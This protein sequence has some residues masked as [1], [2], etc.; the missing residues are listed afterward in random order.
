MNGLPQKQRATTAA[1]PGRWA[2]TFVEVLLRMTW[3]ETKLLVREPVTLVFSFAFPVLVLVLLGGIFGGQHMDGG[4]YAG[5]KMMDWYVPSYIGLVIASIGTVSLPVHLS[6]YRERGVLRR[7][8]ASGMSEWALLGSQFL[9]GVGTCLVGA[10]AT[11]A[12]HLRLRRGRARV[13]LRRG[14]RLRG[15]RVRLLGAR[16]AHRLAR[17]HGTRR[18]G[19]RPADLVHHDVHLGH[20]RAARATCP[21]GCW[22]WPRPCPSTTS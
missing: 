6:T 10:L 16:R 18:P 22:R 12:R 11:G 5:L 13:D 8:R 3:V 9:V 7:F 20:Q 15:G 4:A 21:P 14:R 17:A 19:R 2:Q 1:S